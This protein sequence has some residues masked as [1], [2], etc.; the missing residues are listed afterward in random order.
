MLDTLTNLFSN[1]G[2]PVKA[3]ITAVLSFAAVG[4]AAK[5]FLLAMKDFGSK[6]WPEGITWL[7]AS[8]IVFALPVLFAIFVV[9]GVRIG[10]EAG[11]AFQ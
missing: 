5:P 6:K 7:A 2:T 1:L 9:F 10:T 3:V 11:T 8:I 4:F